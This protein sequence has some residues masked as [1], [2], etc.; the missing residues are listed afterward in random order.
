LGFQSPPAAGFCLDSK[1]TVGFYMDAA[2]DVHGFVSRG[3]TLISIND[4]SAVLTTQL[5]G[6]R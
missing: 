1:A 5:L 2:G 3:G 6:V 4:P